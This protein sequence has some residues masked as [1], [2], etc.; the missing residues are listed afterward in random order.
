M[1]EKQKL[2]DIIKENGYKW[3]PETKTLEKMI[4]PKFKV[5]DKI[6]YSKGCGTIMTIEKIENGEYIFANNM[7]HTTIES[8]NKWYLVNLVEQKPAWSEEDE[9]K[10]RDVI[11]LVEQGAP[12]QSIR[13]HYTNWLK[14]LKERYTWKP[15][16]LQRSLC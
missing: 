6:Q 5:G 4:I 3:N 15:S 7:G 14:S 9:E 10:F 12:V 2:F 1:K 16:G 11:R 13:D 8:G